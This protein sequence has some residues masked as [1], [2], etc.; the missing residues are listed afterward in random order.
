MSVNVEAGEL[1]VTDRLTLVTDATTSNPAH[2]PVEATEW[3]NSRRVVQIERADRDTVFVN[4]ESTNV[5]WSAEGDGKPLQ[6]VT[7]NGWQQGWI[8]PAGTT[9]LTLEFAL[10]RWYRVA[11]FGGLLLLIPLF[12]LALWRRNT[13]ENGTPA[14]GSAHLGRGRCVRR[15]VQHRRRHDGCR[16][17][18]GCAVRGPLVT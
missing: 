16:V 17:R 15:S 7:V 4:P 13:A 6:P 10:D 11:L 12:A 18:R 2:H 5:G 14:P 9:E 3:T 8:V 1:F